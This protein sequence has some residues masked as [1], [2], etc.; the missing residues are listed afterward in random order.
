M[1]QRLFRAFV[2]VVGV[3][4]LTMPGVVLGGAV[5]PHRPAG[6]ACVGGLCDVGPVVAKALTV[7]G[8]KIYCIA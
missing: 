5:G 6:T 7:T 2:P 8:E 4:V 1:R 3:A